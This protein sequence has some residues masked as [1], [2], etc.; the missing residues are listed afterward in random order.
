MEDVFKNFG[1]I[2]PSFGTC[3]Y[4]NILLTNGTGEQYDNFIK[5]VESG[6]IIQLNANGDMVNL[7]MKNSH[8]D[9]GLITK[10]LHEWFDYWKN[11]PPITFTVTRYP[12]FEV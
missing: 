5:W 3:S 10:S 2:I 12:P 6:E 7:W 9:M 11:P 8:Y 1:M 4:K